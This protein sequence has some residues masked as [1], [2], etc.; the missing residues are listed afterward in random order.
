MKIIVDNRER[1]SGISEE[2]SDLDVNF[3][4]SQ[5]ELGDFILSD[6]CVVERK[7]ISDFL[8]S[9]VDG[10]LFSQ[11]KNL[12]DHFDKVLYILEGDISEIYYLRDISENAIIS[13]I[14]SLNLDYNIPIFHSE[15]IESTAKILK[16]LLRREYKKSEGNDS[17]RV[18]RKFWTVEDEQKYLVEGL[19][20]VGPKLAMNLL[21]YFKS[22]K[23]IFL[24]SSEELQKIEKIGKKKADKIKLVL[25]ENNFN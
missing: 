8:S 6:D 21:K 17:F 3:E 2:L 14:L 1:K 24:A 23:N 18:G 7:T 20:G 4:F 5:L 22:P 25:D 11:A 9:L 10:R 16:N 12:K 15:D 13:S 19:P